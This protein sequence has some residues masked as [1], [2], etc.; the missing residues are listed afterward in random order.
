MWAAMTAAVFNPIFQAFAGTNP[1]FTT[2]SL[3]VLGSNCRFSCDKARRELG[4]TARPLRDTLADSV[5][6]FRANGML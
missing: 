6:W 4:F 1:R 2:Y 3:R 5:D